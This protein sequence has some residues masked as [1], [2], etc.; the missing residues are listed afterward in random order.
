MTKWKTEIEKEEGDDVERQTEGR[1][2]S[3]D[4]KSA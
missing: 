1:K 3:K 2:E 4:E